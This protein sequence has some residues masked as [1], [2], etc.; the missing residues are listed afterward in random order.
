MPDS[1]EKIVLDLETQ[2]GFNE[3]GRNNLDQ[4]RVSVVGIYSYKEQGFKIFSE[5]EIQKLIPYLERAQLV[6]G[7]NIKKFDYPVLQPYVHFALDSLNTLDIFEI[8]QEE[9]GF[10]LSLDSI[11][12]A[13]LNTKKT[14]SGLDALRYFREGDIEKLTQYCKQDVFI[15]REVYEYGRKHGH[16]LY[17]HGQATQTIPISWG[18]CASINEILHNAFTQRRTIEIE[19]STPAANAGKRH[20]REIDIYKFDLGK[21]IAYCHLRNDMRTFNIQRILSVKFTDKTYTIPSDFNFH[22]FKTEQ[23]F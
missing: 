20:L 1:A 19:Y 2:R 18:E 15:T 5:Q 12:K 4:L 17:Y 13:T 3:V 22:K 23:K 8:I 9:M 21:V 7:F 11:A 14:G 16:L 6:I 10:R